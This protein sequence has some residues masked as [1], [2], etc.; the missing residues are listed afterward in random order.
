[1]KSRILGRW[2]IG[3]AV[4][5]ALL[6]LLLV[7]ALQVAYAAI[8]TDFK[9][10]AN[11]TSSA[12]DLGD[13]DWIGSIVQANNSTYYEGMS[14]AQ[15][16]IFGNIE[17]QP[18]DVH[19][20]TFAHDATK[21]GIHAYDFLTSYDQA[22]AAAADSGVPFND[23]DGQA[24]DGLSGTDLT[25][26]NL[27]TGAN[28]VDV[29]A[30]D[31][32]FVSKDGST[33]SRIDAYEAIYGNRT[34]RICAN[35][36]VSGAV[37]TLSHSVANGADTGDSEILY[38]LTYTS[39]GSQL[40]LEM[41]PHISV[42]GNPAVNPVAWG[43]GLGASNISGGPYHVN[44]GHLDG[45]ALGSQDNQIKGADILVLP[46]SI[47]VDKVTDPSGD[48]TGFD[49]ELRDGAGALLASFPL[50]DTQPPFGSGPLAAGTYYVE[51]LGPPAGW[52]LDSI[53]CVD[54]SGGTTT[55]DN[56]A[57]IDL[58]Q[59]EDV[60]CTFYDS[61][62]PSYLTLVKTVI[63]NNGGSLQV[64]DFPLFIDGTP[65]TSGEAYEVQPDVQLT[66]TESQQSGYTASAWG[67][68]CAP[69]GTITLSAG[70]SM[71][72]TITNDDQQ[73]YITVVKNVTNDDGG[74]ALPNDFLLTLEGNAVTSGVAVPVNPGTYTAAETLLP[75]YT[76]EGFS[77]DCDSNGDVTVALG[78]SKSCTLANDDVQNSIDIE[79]WTNGRDADAPVG[80]YVHK[81]DPINWTYKVTNTG[82]V[83][84]SN[85]AVTDSK[86]VTV[87]CPKTTLGVGE[88]MT[89]TASGIAT[90]GQY[91]NQG[92][93][94]GYYE[95][96][97][98]SDVDPSHYFGIDPCIKL[99]K[100]G[101][102]SASIGRKVTYVFRVTNC[103][104]ATPLDNVKL[105]DPRFPGMGV[106]NLGHLDPGQTKQHSYVY[107]VKESDGTEIINVAKATGRDPL[108]RVVDDSD[109]WIVPI[110]PKQ[111][112]P[113]EFVPE[114][115]SLAL[116]ASALA[117][118]AGY[119]R[120][121]RRKK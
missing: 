24:C 81:G 8:S 25:I 105:S 109:N 106:V 112:P 21:G 32:P 28:C 14:V 35:Q 86:G 45:A 77:G 116:L 90:E 58:A 33:Q 16:S 50:T 83:P 62:L 61:R 74:S 47:I 65:A 1:M 26:C 91:V 13:C 19:T 102:T 121:R 107:T 20:L 120:M 30:P 100:R 12:G 3:A 10:C 117:P 53:E 56:T 84:L 99:V 87:S 113:E 42:S 11:G 48:P 76:F 38:T 39:T 71:T 80:P 57:T 101:P 37:L 23:F 59:G 2:T 68:D 40:L 5:P 94:E 85:V 17:T 4:A 98:T 66:V 6:I 18:G 104:A 54:P 114:W 88:T 92:T 49:F 9:Q 82:D 79:K 110:K 34:V 44:L 97:K 46:G 73:A 95:S 118:L 115:G 89:C 15:R 119:A 22:V 103:S 72:C 108:G 63:N 51:E 60:T 67:T 36:P 69:D 96:I 93:A 55:L 75:G 29:T 41:A 78:E 52:A 111:Q 70:E 64:G 7:V 31:D 27:R 43:I